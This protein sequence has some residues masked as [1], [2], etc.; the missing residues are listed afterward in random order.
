[1]KDPGG[2]VVE[3]GSYR[4]LAFT[5]RDLLVDRLCD[6][7]GEGGVV[8][9]GDHGG[10]RVVFGLRDQVARDEVG[11]GGLVGEDEH[12]AGPARKSISTSP[13]TIAS[14]RR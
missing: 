7:L 14:R 1:V 6:R 2:V 13:C 12:L 3:G 10:V 5:A 8:G 4:L 9:D 11:V